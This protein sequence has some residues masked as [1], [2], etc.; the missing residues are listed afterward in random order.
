MEAANTSVTAKIKNTEATS[1]NLVSI[2]AVGANGEYTGDNLIADDVVLPSGK[3]TSVEFTPVDDSTKF[4][5]GF[6]P[7]QG[8]GVTADYERKSFEETKDLPQNNI[9]SFDVN[10]SWSG[11][12]DDGDEDEIDPSTLARQAGEKYETVVDPTDPEFVY[13]VYYTITPTRAVVI[14]APEEDYKGDKVV[15]SKRQEISP[16]RYGGS[17]RKVAQALVDKMK[18]D[19]PAVEAPADAE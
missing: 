3:E 16:R 11:G 9:I 18:V 17:F 13:A 2:F 19:H 8:T 10:S 6:S 1:M 4:V 12:G 15:S 7:F 14:R 5:F